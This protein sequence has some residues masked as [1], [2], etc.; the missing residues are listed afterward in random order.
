MKMDE[1]SVVIPDGK[2]AWKRIRIWYEGTSSRWAMSMYA[3]K[4]MGSLKLNSGQAASYLSE[5]TD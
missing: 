5:M 1:D 2:E 4:K 3:N